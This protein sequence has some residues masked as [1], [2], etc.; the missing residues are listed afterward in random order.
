MSPKIQFGEYVLL[1]ALKCDFGMW[2]KMWHN[3]TQVCPK[4][5]QIRFN[6]NVIKDKCDPNVTQMWL[7][8]DSS[9][10][11]ICLK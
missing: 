6:W 4:M 7:K 5:S 9:V 2:H 11:E 10:T 8:Y 1:N 3:V